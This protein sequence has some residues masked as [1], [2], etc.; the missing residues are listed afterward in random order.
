M[1][2]TSPSDYSEQ[3]ETHFMKE[4]EHEIPENDKPVFLEAEENLKE[5]PLESGSDKE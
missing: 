3:D 5:L 2:K 4:L 1:A